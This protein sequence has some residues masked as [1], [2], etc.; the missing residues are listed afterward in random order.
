[1]NNKLWFE[2]SE[3]FHVPQ[4]TPYPKRMWMQIKTTDTHIFL[5][6]LRFH[7]SL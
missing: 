3:S 6:Y 2:T 4:N 5:K 7:D 1:M